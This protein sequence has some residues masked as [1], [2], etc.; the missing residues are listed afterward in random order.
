VNYRALQVGNT[1]SFYSSSGL[2]AIG[3]NFFD[4]GTS[5]K[6]LTSSFSQAYLQNNSGEHVWY[7]A[8]SGTANAVVPFTQA[9]TLN[10]NGNLVL[11][12]GQTT[13][14]GVGI[15]FPAT[16]S[17]SSDANTLDDY[18]EGDWTPSLGGN[19][20]F[21]SRSGRYVKIGK[22]VSVLFDI[23]VS[24]LGTGNANQIV[25]IP[26]TAEA[27]SIT[28]GGSIGFFSGLA[29]S[30]VSMFLRIDGG[31]SSIIVS[32]MTG[33]GTAINTN[34]IFQNNTRFTGCITYITSS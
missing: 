22:L 19:T 33:A 16:Q 10:N 29:T 3:N 7:V 6:Y 26:F 32:G 23:Q 8:P 17:A 9:L 4:D 20:T 1:A 11:R 27:N 25:N 2:T 24:V 14:N 31:G 21:T 5:N 30:V 15:T 18:E 13:A 12:G 34:T 28:N